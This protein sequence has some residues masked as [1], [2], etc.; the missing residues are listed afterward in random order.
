MKKRWIAFLMMV[1]VLAVVPQMVLAA[2]DNHNESV[3]P[4]ATY[5]S[6][7]SAELSS[8]GIAKGSVQMAKVK[9]FTLTLI[10]QKYDEKYGVWRT[11][12]SWSKD[13]TVSASIRESSS[14]DSG[15]TYRAKSTVK[16]YDD[17]GKTIETASYYSDEVVG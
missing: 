8:S 7:V 11:V 16:V 2:A 15:A 4:L 3:S 6:D 17:N 10:L 13:G 5:V 12:E 14:L 1:L 9:D